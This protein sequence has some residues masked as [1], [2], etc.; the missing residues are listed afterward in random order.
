MAYATLD[1]LH[2]EGLPAA[3]F[4]G[5][6]APDEDTQQ[7]ALDDASEEAD[8]YIASK[9]TLPLSAPYD[10]SLIHDVVNIAVWHLI[11]RRGFDP[12]D[13]SDAVFRYRLEDAMNHLKRVADG[14]ARLKVVQSAPVSLQ[15][16]VDTAEP[17]GFGGCVPGIGSGWGI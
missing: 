15:P 8:S 4:D 5:P 3:F 16:D 17:R 12:D 9:Y 11:C 7:A 13:K 10:K 6:L 2:R 1:D 14:K